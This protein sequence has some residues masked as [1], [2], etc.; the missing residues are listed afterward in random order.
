M[1]FITRGSLT[2]L[3]VLADTLLEEGPGASCYIP[4]DIAMSLA[5]SAV[6][7]EVIRGK[8]KKNPDSD[9][10]GGDFT[11]ALPSESVDVLRS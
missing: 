1:M 10:A 2:I 11:E 3:L 4:I 6:L 9:P 7:F 5:P 8:E